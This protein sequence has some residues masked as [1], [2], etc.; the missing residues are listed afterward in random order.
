MGLRGLEDGER[1]GG[2]AEMKPATVVGGDM[3]VVAGAG[4]KE[5]AELVVTP[6]EAL[7]GGEAPEAAHASDAAFD[8]AV[9]LFQAVVFVSAGP[10]RNPS[11]Q[12]GADRPRVGAVP[13]RGDGKRG[14]EA[15]L[16]AR[17][18][19]VLCRFGAGSFELTL[20]PTLV[21]TRRVAG[22]AG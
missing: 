4:A 6:T 13:V 2:M 12:R 15:R 17:V 1:G 11:A 22:I 21:T 9:V 20:W 10:M 5:V 7:G 19:N 18:L 16:P 14:D 3:L 8:A